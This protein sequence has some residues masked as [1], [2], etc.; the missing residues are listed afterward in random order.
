MRPCMVSG[1]AWVRFGGTPQQA[2]Q[3]A[4]GIVSPFDRSS[5]NHPQGEAILY[6][7]L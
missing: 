2:S 6:E 1:I 7:V 5:H 3:G 4:L